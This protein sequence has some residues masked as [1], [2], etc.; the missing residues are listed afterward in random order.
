MRLSLIAPQLRLQQ[1]IDAVVA[2]DI[3][4]FQPCREV[5]P[6]Q[7]ATTIPENLKMKSTIKPL[8]GWCTAWRGYG[9]NTG[10]MQ[11]AFNAAKIRNLNMPLS[12]RV[13]VAGYSVS[14]R[15]EIPQDQL[16]KSMQML[17]VNADNLSNG[18]AVASRDP[19]L[20]AVDDAEA[21][22]LQNSVDRGL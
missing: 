9:A 3:A 13:V 7:L 20:V 18:S 10:A 17:R 2:N 8:V 16:Q 19:G 1:W 22:D 14:L 6:V 15:R 12:W 5:D 11:T 4:R 21:D